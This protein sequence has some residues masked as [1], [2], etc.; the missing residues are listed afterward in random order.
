VK[1]KQR[2]GGAPAARPGMSSEMPPVPVDQLKPGAAAAV[3]A[4]P[5]AHRAGADRSL[6]PDRRTPS[7]R[8]GAA[9][10]RGSRP[11]PDPGG[12]ALRA[13]RA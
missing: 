3:C 10:R 8:A 4:Q 6:Q 7:W 9:A 13:A 1:G 2:V 11:L 12:R 5:P